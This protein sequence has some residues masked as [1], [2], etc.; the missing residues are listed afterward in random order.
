MMRV[1]LNGSLR[2]VAA[3]VVAS[4]AVAGAAAAHHGWSNYDEKKTL[5]VTGGWIEVCPC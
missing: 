3:V 2:R 5:N 1:G 4:L